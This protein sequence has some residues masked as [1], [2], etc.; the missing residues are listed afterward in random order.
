M[1]RI[2]SIFFV[3]ITC[4]VLAPSVTH[5]WCGSPIVWNCVQCFFSS[6]PARECS[7][8]PTSGSTELH[9]DDLQTVSCQIEGAQGCSEQHDCA[10]TSNCEL[11]TVYGEGICSGAYMV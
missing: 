4:I 9:F 2:L 6:G 11:V 3:S 10:N 8:A 5:A 1:A 7:A